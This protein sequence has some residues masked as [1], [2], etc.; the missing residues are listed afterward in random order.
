MW[1]KIII[2]CEGFDLIFIYY[3]I[4]KQ[5]DNGGNVFTHEGKFVLQISCA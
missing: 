2:Q 5:T 3:S 4:I 1:L